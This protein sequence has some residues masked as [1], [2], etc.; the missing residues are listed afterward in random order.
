MEKLEANVWAEFGF[1]F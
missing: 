1:R